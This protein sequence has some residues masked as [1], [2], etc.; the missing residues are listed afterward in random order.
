MSTSNGVHLHLSLF[1]NSFVD[2]SVFG[3][4]VLVGTLVLSNAP[5]GPAS[6]PS[7]TRAVQNT[8]PDDPEPESKPKSRTKPKSNSLER[9]EIIPEPSHESDLVPTPAEEF[10]AAPRSEPEPRQYDDPAPRRP[11]R[12]PAPTTREEERKAKKEY[13]QF[14][15]SKDQSVP[16]PDDRYSEPT[17]RRPAPE[18]FSDFE[19]PARENKRLHHA[20]KETP[21]WSP[22]D[23]QRSEGQRNSPF[24][25]DSNRSFSGQRQHVWELRS[26]RGVDGVF[27][28]KYVCIHCSLIME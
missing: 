10:D 25:G 26:V 5:K 12:Q 13:D 28:N 3:G 24:E 9:P 18:P 14:D 27:R 8:A 23:Y 6:N 16:L 15:S 7:D 22:N 1:G 17:P 4:V 2:F 21:D 20:H 11:N 19:S